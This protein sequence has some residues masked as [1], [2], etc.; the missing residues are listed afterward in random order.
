MFSTLDRNILKQ[1]LFRATE[2]EDSEIN[3]LRL[4]LFGNLAGPI[5]QFEKLSQSGATYQEISANASC[6]AGFSR[7]V[8]QEELID[9]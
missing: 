5:S 4:S 7:N 1:L 2:I 6:H 9:C 8:S 3:H